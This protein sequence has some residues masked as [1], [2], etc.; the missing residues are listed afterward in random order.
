MP[1]F[2]LLVRNDVY[3][4]NLSEKS[5]CRFLAVCLILPESEESLFLS[6]DF[7]SC[8]NPLPECLV[9]SK[10][11]LRLLSALIFMRRLGGIS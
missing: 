6:T 5:R 3:L 8:I 1:F 7:R 10:E 2:V 11:N 4:R 9:G